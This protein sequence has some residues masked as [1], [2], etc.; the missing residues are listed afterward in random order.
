MKYLVVIF[1]FVLA[2]SPVFANPFSGGDGSPENPFLISSR[3]D[4]KTMADSMSIV[5][6]QNP[7]IYHE[8]CFKHYKVTRNIRD[9]VRDVIFNFAGV[10]D[11]Q[12]YKI[13]LAIDKTKEQSNAAL[14]DFVRGNAIIKNVVL[15]G[16]VKNS[17]EMSQLSAGLVV[18]IMCEGWTFDDPGCKNNVQ[19]I[20]CVNL[21]KITGRSA[22]GIVT[23]FQPPGIISGCINLG[24][25]NSDYSGSS[26]ILNS[27]ATGR[28]N[29][30]MNC[31]NSGFIYGHNV[32]NDGNGW[33]YGTGGIA[34]RIFDNGFY[35]GGPDN[36]YTIFNSINTGIVRGLG[37]IWGVGPTKK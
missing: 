30:V 1:L 11:G 17:F 4:L 6:W 5:I 24:A 36:I 25:M 28:G 26:G 21:A 27:I 9:S 23:S 19:I 34:S 35:P 33:R 10:F 22:T 8:L 16:Y 13:T 20:N 31:I 2:A 37:R 32:W 29:Y 15:D 14:F 12:G 18:N 7:P 3:K